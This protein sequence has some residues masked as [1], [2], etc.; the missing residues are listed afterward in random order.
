MQEIKKLISSC[1]YNVTKGGALLTKASTHGLCFL[2]NQPKFKSSTIKDLK[3]L[4]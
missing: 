2:K 4:F 1:D 3:S